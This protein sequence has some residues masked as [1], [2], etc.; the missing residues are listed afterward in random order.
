MELLILGSI[1][2]LR[3]V[4]NITGKACSAYAPKE[5]RE[6]M[7]YM[8]V[9]MCLSAAA[10]AALLLISGFSWKI[11]S[12]LSEIGWVIALGTGISLTI[13]GICSLLAMRGA[14]V[15]LTSLFGTAGLLVPTLSG[16][17]LFDQRVTWGQWLGIGFLFCAA[18]LLASSSQKT[19][20][21]ISPK[22]IIFLF[23]SM[24]ANGSTMLLQTLYKAWV[25][26]GN[27]S[28]YSFL[29]FGIPAVTL[30]AVSLFWS[31][32]VQKE[33]PKTEKKLLLYTLFASAA[34]FGVSQISTIAS[35]II[36]IAVLFPVSDGGNTII[37][38]LVAAVLF[39]EKLTVRSIC[40]VLI[41]FTGLIMIKLLSGT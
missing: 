41:G 4:Q 34:V 25:P 5:P 30:F 12:S 27:V 32:R 20:G 3:L 1:L 16:I 22:T 29:Q 35:A 24:L 40:G 7:A 17:I 36:P 31:I 13:S 9:R 23:G 14:S 38:T 19:N 6:M 8:S 21:K 10:A 2:L 15:A 39:R 11:I 33:Y 28:L 37:A 18:I 26:A